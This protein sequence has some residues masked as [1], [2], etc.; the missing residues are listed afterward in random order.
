VPWIARNY[1]TLHYA[2]LRSDFGEE[3][4]LGNQPGA[5]GLIVGSKHPVWSE[6]ERNEYVRMGEI[7]YVAAKRRLAIEFIRDQPGR[8][9]V[10]TLKRV[11]YFWCGGPDDPRVHPS[12]V[13]VRMTFLFMAGF[14]GFWGCLRGIR[15]NITGSWLLL[16]VLIC[17]PLVFYITHTHV[18]YRHP[19][20]AILFLAA[21]YLFVSH[22]NEKP[23]H[24]A[25][26]ANHSIKLETAS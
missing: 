11:A 18:R 21:V 15:R 5:D 24:S 1:I 9:A 14:L 2:G 13:V 4:Y 10:I 20:D 19:L 23:A 12:D 17:Y 25:Q 16:G 7:A 22:R 3:L 8:F 6:K 26:Q